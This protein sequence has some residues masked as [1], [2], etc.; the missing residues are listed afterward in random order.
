MGALLS[1]CS[2]SPLA[3]PRV[4][5]PLKPQPLQDRSKKASVLDFSFDLFPNLVLR[6][7]RSAFKCQKASAA[8]LADSNQLARRSQA[9]VS[10]VI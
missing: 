5:H 8:D 2:L 1:A 10:C 9:L 7:Q 3:S 4:R 6:P